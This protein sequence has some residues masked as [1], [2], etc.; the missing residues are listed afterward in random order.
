MAHKKGQ[1]STRNGR[2]SK[3]QFLGVKRYGGEFVTIGTILVR[4]KGLDF[5]AGRHVAQARDHTLYAMRDG[6]V[7]FVGRRIS[8]KPQEAAAGAS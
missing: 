7:T 1:G 4:Q 3:A 8:I 2:D 6:E 5:V